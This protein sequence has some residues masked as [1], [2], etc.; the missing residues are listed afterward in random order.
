MPGYLADN[1]HL[2]AAIS[3]VSKVRERLYRAHREGTR[4]GT[5]P[6]RIV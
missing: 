1:N 3:R 4:I 2:S 5:Y 6:S